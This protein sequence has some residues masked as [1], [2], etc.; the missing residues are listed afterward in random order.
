MSKKI[1]TLSFKDINGTPKTLNFVSSTNPKGITTFELKNEKKRKNTKFFTIGNLSLRQVTQFDRFLRKNGF[2]NL[3]HLSFKLLCE[4]A[5][6][7]LNIPKVRVKTPCRIY[8]R[9]SDKVYDLVKALFY[10]RA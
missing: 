2:S 8:Y 4:L 9:Y 10:F 7:Y 1:E 6:V 5:S 3:K